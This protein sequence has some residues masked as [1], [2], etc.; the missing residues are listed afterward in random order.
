[1]SIYTEREMLKYLVE[2]IQEEKRIVRGMYQDIKQQE[3]TLLD[4][5]RELDNIGRKETQG[6]Y[7]VQGLISDLSNTLNKVSGLIPRIPIETILE[8]IRNRASN[9]GVTIVEGSSSILSNPEYQ[10]DKQNLIFKENQKALSKRNLEVKKRKFNAKSNGKVLLEFIKNS[11]RPVSVSEIKEFLDS[12]GYTE[13]NTSNRMTAMLKV[14]PRLEKVS[15][16]FYQYNTT[17]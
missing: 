11:G 5:M 14:Y 7:D 16:G 2:C 12:E 3:I 13:G 4:R 17:S 6:V 10:K 15:H 8:D 9:S 1:M